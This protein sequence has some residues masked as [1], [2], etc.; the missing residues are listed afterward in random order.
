[1]CFSVESSFIGAGVLTVAG[2]ATVRATKNPKLYGL[3]CVPLVF[4][5]HQFLEGFV[6]WSIAEPAS[7]MN[8][9]AVNAFVLLGFG[10]WPVY[11]PAALAWAE[12]ERGR[13]R[14]FWAI[15]VIELYMLGYVAAQVPH[16]PVAVREHS[17]SYTAGWQAVHYMLFGVSIMTPF[18]SSIPRMWRLGVGLVGSFLTAFWFRQVAAASVWCFFAAWL[19]LGVYLYLRWLRSSAN[20]APGQLAEAVV[21][22]RP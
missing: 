6:W 7:L 22:S 8:R 12:P 18:F 4:A 13:R 21:V 10:V 19:S 2:I 5:S 16:I 1:M 3:A 17:L 15:A 14:I 20:R 9:V 11:T